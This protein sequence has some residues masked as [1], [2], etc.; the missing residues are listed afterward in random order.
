MA[1]LQVVAVAAKL[2]RWAEEACADYAR[3]MPKGYE[4]ERINI[5]DERRLA[6]ALPK[7]PRLV[8]LDER[9]RDMTTAQFAE[10]LAVPSAF[11]IGGAEGLSQATKRSAQLTL[12]L[13]AMT[14]PHAL[15]QVLLLE[16]LYRAAT[17]LT[18]HPY[19]RA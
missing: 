6:A 12:R 15:A 8:V 5:K 11:L 10:L 4:L 14:L 7:N 18:G 9:G 3:R 17:F 16:Q 19:H 13:S 2:P 1:R